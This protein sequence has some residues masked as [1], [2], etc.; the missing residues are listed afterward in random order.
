MN[1]NNLIKA[2]HGMAAG[3]GFWDEERN[4]S[5][6]LM[7]IVSEV[8]EAQEALRKNFYADRSMVLDLSHD[9]VLNDQDEEFTY[10]TED[11]K[12]HFEKHVKS[13]FEDELADVAIRLFDLCGGLKIDLE[14]H[15]ALKMHYNSTRP[16]KHGKAF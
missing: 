16:R 12:Q 1:I 7:L 15:I 10:N 4:V 8:A 11:W 5:E 13:S 6:M 2:S 3:N 14:K 9:L